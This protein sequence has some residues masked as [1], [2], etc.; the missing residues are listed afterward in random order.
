VSQKLSKK[1]PLS[2][3]VELCSVTK[4]TNT[5]RGMPGDSSYDYG[6]FMMADA[7]S[8]Y[9]LLLRRWF[10]KHALTRDMFSQLRRKR[11]RWLMEF[12]AGSQRAD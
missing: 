12:W 8:P 9:T 5:Q 6:S 11:M 3:A 4:Y 10:D 2:G 7:L 1:S